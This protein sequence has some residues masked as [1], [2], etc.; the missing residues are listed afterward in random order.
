MK[1]GD[2]VN[3]PNGLGVFF[4]T[5]EKDST[6]AYVVLK[7]P[8]DNKIFVPLVEEGQPVWE[9]FPCDTFSM[10]DLTIDKTLEQRQQE[11]QE[12]MMRARAQQQAELNRRMAAFQEQQRRAHEQQNNQNQNR[13]E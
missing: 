10:S 9:A 13:N 7:T 5:L 3:T 12:A 6:K 4:D 11:A 8:T 1:H 2:Q